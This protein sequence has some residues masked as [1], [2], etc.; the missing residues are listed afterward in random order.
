MCVCVCVCVCVCMFGRCCRLTKRHIIL[1]VERHILPYLDLVYGL[2]DG[3]AM[4][5]AAHAQLFQLG[6]LQCGEHVACDA[7]I[8]NHVISKSGGRLL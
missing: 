2:E 4:A 7:L 5:H 1:G 3:K 8:C 6:V